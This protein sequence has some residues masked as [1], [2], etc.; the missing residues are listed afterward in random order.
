MKT[1]CFKAYALHVGKQ[2]AF[3]WMAFHCAWLCCIMHTRHFYPVNKCFWNVLLTLSTGVSL[4][5]KNVIS[6]SFLKPPSVFAV[7]TRM[8][9]L[10]C[11]SATQLPSEMCE[12]CLNLGFIAVLSSPSSTLSNSRCGKPNESSVFMKRIK[13]YIFFFSVYL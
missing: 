11:N 6:K 8:S 9:V 5:F 3:I 10:E 1:H 12:Y 2:E 7:H 4:L 13:I